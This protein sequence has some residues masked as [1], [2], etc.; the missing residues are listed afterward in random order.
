VHRWAI[1]SYVHRLG[2]AGEFPG[3]YQPPEV[4]V[5]LLGNSPEPDVFGIEAN[6]LMAGNIL[7]LAQLH[8]RH[9][10]RRHTDYHKTH[11]HNK[12]LYQLS[13]VPPIANCQLPI[14]NCQ[15]LLIR[16]HQRDTDAK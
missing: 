1:G 2:A 5:L 3:V 12:V 4:A 16:Y 14:A 9:G 10:N 7:A 6:H 13:A 8:Q 11:S 15:P